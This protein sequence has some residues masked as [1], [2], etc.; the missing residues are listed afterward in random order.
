MVGSLFEADA[1]NN[2]TFTAGEIRDPR[3]NLPLSLALGTGS[4]ILLYLLAN[5]AYLA[6]CRCSLTRTGAAAAQPAR[7]ETARA[8][9]RGN[10]RGGGGEGGAEEVSEAERDPL[11]ARHRPRDA[12]SVSARRCCSCG[13]RNVGTCADGPGRSWSRRSAA[14]TA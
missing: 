14:S 4:V 6:A 2:I 3:R 13:R 1:W 7:P 9:R 11:H 12:T 8:E 5:L 10:G